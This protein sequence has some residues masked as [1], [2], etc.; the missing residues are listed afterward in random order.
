MCEIL[1]L[2]RF[3]VQFEKSEKREFESCLGH[4]LTRKKSLHLFIYKELVGTPLDAV[5][6]RII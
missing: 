4:L 5:I 2:I 6:G 3:W 1:V